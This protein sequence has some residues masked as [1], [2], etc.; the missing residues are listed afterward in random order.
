MKWVD[1]V[2][3][4]LV[5][6]MYSMAYGFVPQANRRIVS[7]ALVVLLGMAG[8]RCLMLVDEPN[9]DNEANVHS[10][11]RQSRPEGM[12]LQKC[13]ERKKN[14]SIRKVT[15]VTGYCER[16]HHIRAITDRK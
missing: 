11:A 6:C 13:I 3:F 1:L 2:W 7:G 14:V 9:R 16:T 5:A 4:G 8:S 12:K 15:T 10:K